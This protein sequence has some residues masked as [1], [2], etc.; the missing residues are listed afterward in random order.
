MILQTFFF[1]T[2]KFLSLL[3]NYSHNFFEVRNHILFLRFNQCNQFSHLIMTLMCVLTLCF[4][5]YKC[6][7]WYGS[8]S[9]HISVSLLVVLGRCFMCWRMYCR[10]FLMYL[11][12]SIISLRLLKPVFVLT[13]KAT[14]VWLWEK[15]HGTLWESLMGDATGLIR[16]CEEW[17]D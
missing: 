1:S 4:V 8:H 17:L 12:N 10:L 5:E 16:C 14:K 9:F 3:K 11:G 6:R 2:A 7:L 13:I 15:R